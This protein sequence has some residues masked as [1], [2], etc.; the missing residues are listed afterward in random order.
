MAIVLP[1]LA[2][3]GVQSARGGIEVPLVF[4]A[5]G[6]ACLLVILLE[7]QGR[8]G[9]GDRGASKLVATSVPSSRTRFNWSPTLEVTRP[10]IAGST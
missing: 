9:I 1:A 8:A 6:L 3:V 2:G 5:L 10:L 7:V 4:T